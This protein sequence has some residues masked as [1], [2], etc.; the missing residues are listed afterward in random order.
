MLLEDWQPPDREALLEEF[1]D[2]RAANK[3]KPP[4]SRAA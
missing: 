3:R 1:E 4:R 2:R